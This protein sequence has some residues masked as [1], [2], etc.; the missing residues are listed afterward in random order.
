MIS[1]QTFD[2]IQRAKAAKAKPRKRRHEKELLFL[3]LATCASCGYC[4]TG[5]RHVKKS[6]LRFYYYRCSHKDKKQ[7]CEGRRF[8][9]QEKF[10]E[11][12]KRNAQ[13][14]VLP[15]IWQ[16]RFLVKIE[17]W[18]SEETTEK[19]SQ[20]ARI[21]GELAIVKAKI[22]RLNAAFTDGTLDIPEFKELKNP[23]VPKKVELE[24]K[25]TALERT[26]TNRLEPLRNWISEANTLEK[27]VS[28]NNFAEMKSFLQKVGSNRVLS[29]Q[30][31]TVSFKK[32]WNSLA[33]TV[34]V[35]S[36]T[37]DVSEQCSGWWTLQDSNLP[38]PLCKSGAL[39]DELR[40]PITNANRCNSKRE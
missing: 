21:K 25:I 38:P 35:A 20:I 18:E 40:A 30:T 31:L 39:P 2:A 22:D 14:V 23:L 12:I 4:I 1:K 3:N 13:R 33:E 17:S 29:D 8:I 19:Q 5:E 32:P 36:A 24:G 7:R 28:N 34:V 10:A 37:P 16:E 9:R 11:E 6:G 26:K 27:A 15:A